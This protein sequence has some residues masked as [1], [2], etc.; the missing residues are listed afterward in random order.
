MDFLDQLLHFSTLD[1]S[2]LVILFVC[3]LGTG[4]IIEHAPD[5]NLSVSQLMAR[6]RRE[7]MAQMVMR[8][9][10]I[11]DSQTM[12]ALRQGTSFFASATMIAIGGGLALLGNPEQLLGVAS[13]LSLGTTPHAVLD[14]KILVTLLFLANAFL[15]FVWSHRL[16][17]YC[18][19]MMAAVPNDPNDPEAFPR[20]EQ[21]AEINITAG[22]SY[23][24]GLRS[25]YFAL[26]AC[27][28]LLGPVPLIA[29]SLLTVSVM[30]RR[31]FASR[32]RQVLLRPKQ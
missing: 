31:E 15:K 20:A 6:Y 22:R 4:L 23:N 2:A 12:S 27:A 11:F 5:R 19:I 24:R 16:F 32:S 7:W 3:W 10:R 18:H 9:P 30:Y 26:A 8:D 29:A 28:W 25:I 17:G 1:L 13:E 14:I 21:A